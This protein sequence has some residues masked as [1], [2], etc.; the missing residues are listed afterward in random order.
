MNTSLIF[1]C[2]S[3]DIFGHYLIIFFKHAKLQRSL[4]IT[5][6]FVELL[7]VYKY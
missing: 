4:Q 6:M 5:K 3:A 2:I 7:F 1:C